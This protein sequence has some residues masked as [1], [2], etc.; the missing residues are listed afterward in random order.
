MG[1]TRAQKRLILMIV[2]TIIIYMSGY[3]AYFFLSEYIQTREL[4]IIQNQTYVTVLYLLVGR[5]IT[6]AFSILNRYTD[7]KNLSKVALTL[8]GLS[9][10]LAVRQPLI[11]QSLCPRLVL[12]F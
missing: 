11:W 6:G 9:F 12:R 7:Y 10:S 2:D 4:N 3:I 8:A 5:G 1:I